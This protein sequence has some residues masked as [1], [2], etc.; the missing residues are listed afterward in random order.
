MTAPTIKEQAFAVEMAAVNLRGHVENLRSLVGKG[1]R[2]AHDLEAA[3][4][5]LPNLEQAAKTLQFIERY[6]PELKAI[7]ARGEAA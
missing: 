6:E 1:K 4:A 5:R 2:P 7:I 3:E